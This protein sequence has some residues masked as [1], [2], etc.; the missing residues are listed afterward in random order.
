[1][2]DQE[3]KHQLGQVL[4]RRDAAELRA[5]LE[6]SAARFGDQRQVAAIREKS[7]DEMAEL[8]HRMILSRQDLADLHAESRR[9]LQTR[10][11]RPARPARGRESRRNGG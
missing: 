3:Y 6:A 11:T 5:F 2:T 8:L 10:E 7:S 4:R 1:V 9:W